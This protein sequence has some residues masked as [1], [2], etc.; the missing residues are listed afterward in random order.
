[1][2]ETAEP[3]G[4]VRDTSDTMRSGPAGVGYSFERFSTF[5]IFTF[6]AVSAY[7]CVEVAI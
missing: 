4:R 3:G 5:N 1:M 6:S 2:M 7:L